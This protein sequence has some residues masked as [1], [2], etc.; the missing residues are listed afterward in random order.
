MSQQVDP[1]IDKE[2]P[3]AASTWMWGISGAVV[4]LAFALGVI[5][6]ASA[7]FSQRRNQNFEEYVS[8]AAVLKESQEQDLAQGELSIQDAMKRWIEREN[9]SRQNE[10][11]E[12]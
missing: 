12:Q 2:D 1:K 10:N 3:D 6:V 7:Q 4:T 5:W 11:D 8:P 9:Q